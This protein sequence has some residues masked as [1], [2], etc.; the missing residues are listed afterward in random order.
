MSIM[1][2]W[3]ISY[4][5]TTNPVIQPAFTTSQW[6][7]LTYV[8]RLIPSL[9]TKV[10]SALEGRFLERL[11]APHIRV[12][13]V[14]HVSGVYDMSLQHHALIYI[15]QPYVCSNSPPSLNVTHYR[16]CSRNLRNFVS[17]LAGWKI[18]VCKVC[19]FFLWRSWSGF[20]S[21]I[22]ENTVRYV[23]ILL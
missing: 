2:Q 21:S 4:R 3:Y 22:I 10:P 13:S 12:P 19:W 15:V 23:N 18:G 6:R 5:V 14:R 8:C 16:I 17:I 20:Y 9:P 1:H 11:T 7:C